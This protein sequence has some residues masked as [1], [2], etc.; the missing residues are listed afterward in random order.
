MGETNLL[1][2]YGNADGNFRR[3]GVTDDCF[4]SYRWCHTL[5]PLPHGI[6]PPQ[7]IPFRAPMMIPYPSE[8]HSLALG[9][10]EV[11]PVV[12]VANA[13]I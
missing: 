5:T 8:S 7:F 10:E 12:S 1:M 2:G 13:A 9:Q 3:S 4:F 11:G 6:T